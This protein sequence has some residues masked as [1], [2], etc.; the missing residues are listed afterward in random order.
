MDGVSLRFP[1]D[2]VGAISLISEASCMAA[3][4]EK[5]LLWLNWTIK[6]GSSTLLTVMFGMITAGF[7]TYA[8]LFVCQYGERQGLSRVVKGSGYH[9][10]QYQQPESP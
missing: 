4:G 2:A 10:T 9:R 7:A 8:A 5:C 6:Q 1:R 3:Q